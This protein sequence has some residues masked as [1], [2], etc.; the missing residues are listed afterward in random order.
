VGLLVHETSTLYLPE[1]VLKAKAKE[2]LARLMPKDSATR[3]AQVNQMRPNDKVPG[4][5]A[6]E[7]TGL[8]QNHLF[9]P[10]LGMLSAAEVQHLVGSVVEG[11]YGKGP[12]RRS[13]SKGE[14]RSLVGRMVDYLVNVRIKKRTGRVVYGR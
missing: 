3:M 4:V 14:W 8:G 10:S 7:P 13:I 12:E 1:W 2:R 5:V 11:G 6:V 9:V